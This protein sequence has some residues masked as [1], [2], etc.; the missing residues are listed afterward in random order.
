MVSSQTFWR[1]KSPWTWLAED[2]PGELNTSLEEENEALSSW[3]LPIKDIGTTLWGKIE[4]LGLVATWSSNL[5]P[6]SRLQ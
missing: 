2:Q 4:A 1:D 5:D 3:G 6:C